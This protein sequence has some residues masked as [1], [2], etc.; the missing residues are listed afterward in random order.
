M[1]VKANFLRG[2]RRDRKGEKGGGM[3]DDMFNKQYILVWKC[4]T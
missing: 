3:G 1:K 4:P 2:Q